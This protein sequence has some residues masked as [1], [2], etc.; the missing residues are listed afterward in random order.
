MAVAKHIEVVVEKCTGCKLCELACSAV[1][2]G[3]FNPKRSHIQVV[4]VD[5]PE[6]PVPLL[7]DTC[8][9]CFGNPACVSVCL[10]EAIVWKEMDARPARPRVAE[11]K[12]MAH[13][14]LE[15]VSR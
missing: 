5:I 4:L 11:A 10:P 3:Q 13:T 8:D 12:A 14:W 6:I 1:K 9:Y 2:T 7:K 15:S